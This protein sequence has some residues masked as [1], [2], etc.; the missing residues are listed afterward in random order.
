MFWIFFYVC[1]VFYC[2][3]R[4]F[5]NASRYGGCLLKKSLWEFGRCIFGSKKHTGKNEDVHHFEHVNKRIYIYMLIFLVLQLRS[6]SFSFE[7]RLIL[8]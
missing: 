6:L 2:C 4:W 3:L 7:A 8:V 1:F 5:G